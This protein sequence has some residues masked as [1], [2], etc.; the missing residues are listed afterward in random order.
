M[1]KPLSDTHPD[2]K[3]V[4]L[5]LTRETPAWRKWQLIMQHNEL[6]Q[7]L[8]TQGLRRRNPEASEQEIRRGLYELILG[9]ELTDKLYQA[10][11]DRIMEPRLNEITF[12]LKQF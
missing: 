7:G 2:A 11:P 12:A 4:L 9:K 8:M 5:R 6:M 10:A 3:A 1:T